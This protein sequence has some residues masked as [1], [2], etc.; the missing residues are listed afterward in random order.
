[1][2]ENLPLQETRSLRRTEVPRAESSSVTVGE[3]VEISEIPRFA[4]EVPPAAP[5]DL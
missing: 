1:M 2:V 3:S 4:E 5:S